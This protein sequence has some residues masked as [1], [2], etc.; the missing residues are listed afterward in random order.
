MTSLELRI[1]ALEKSLRIETAVVVVRPEE[2]NEQ[3]KKR[4][5]NEFHVDLNECDL[6]TYLIDDIPRPR[7][8]EN[9]NDTR[10]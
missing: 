8:D 9:T 3:A 1:S 6:I 5:E 10:N 2:T 4:Y 7:K